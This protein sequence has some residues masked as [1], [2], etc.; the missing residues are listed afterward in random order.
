MCKHATIGYNTYRH[1]SQASTSDKK[2]STHIVHELQSIKDKTL[3]YEGG[4]VASS[5]Y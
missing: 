2:K 4:Y 3:I 1:T 5:I